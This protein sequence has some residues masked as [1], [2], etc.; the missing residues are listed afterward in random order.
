M[1]WYILDE[2]ARAQ[3]GNFVRVAVAFNELEAGFLRDYLRE[4]HILAQV[5]PATPPFAVAHFPR[6][7]YLWVPAH[8]VA[9][10]IQ[11]LQELDAQWQE[12]PAE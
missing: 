2:S 11:F 8:Q 3:A 4:R 12:E 7:C 1:R 9:G 6:E 10:A 5:S